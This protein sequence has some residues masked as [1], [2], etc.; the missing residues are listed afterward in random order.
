[1]NKSQWNCTIINVTRINA[2]KKFKYKESIRWK[3]GSTQRNNKHQKV[4]IKIA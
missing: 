4:N 2:L 1:M 3:P